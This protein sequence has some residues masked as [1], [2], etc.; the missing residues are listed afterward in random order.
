M[1][2]FGF[3]KNSEGYADPT[4]AEAIKGMMKPGE[5]WAYNGKEVLVI[6]NQG[7]YSNILTLTERPSRDMNVIE[8][9]GRYTVPGM[10]SYAINTKFSHS[11]ERL[12]PGEFIVVLSAVEDALGTQMQT[13]ATHE[14]KDELEFLREVE[15]VHEEQKAKIMDLAKKNDILARK[16]SLI[17][18]MYDELLN[19]FIDKFGSGDYA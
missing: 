10:L 18:G 2:D 6:K 3:Y 11:V 4:A 19:K 5:I 16:L 17:R 7:G 13:E 12:S 14:Q 9:A 1:G 15:A 8:V